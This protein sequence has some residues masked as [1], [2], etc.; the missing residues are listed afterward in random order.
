MKKILSGIMA[1]VMAV[2]FCGCMG[3]YESESE[4]SQKQEQVQKTFGVGD[5]QTV[6]GVSLTVTNVESGL[7][8]GDRKS[9][10]G[11][12][13]KV[14]FTMQN[15]NDEPCRISYLYFTL[16][17]TYTI[18]ETTY[19]MTNIESGGFYLVKGNTYDFYTIFDCK[20]KHTEADMVF[21]WEK[22]LFD[23]REWVI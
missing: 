14:Y 7:Y 2:S 21:E 6:K 9:E 22:G 8:C 12:W 1:G 20:Y 5:T 18:R 19:L 13:V 10:N 11:S 4:S 23:T 16:N 15:E 3:G 17:D